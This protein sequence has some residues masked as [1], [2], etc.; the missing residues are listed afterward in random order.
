MLRSFT[1]IIKNPWKD[2][3]QEV[4]RKPTESGSLLHK[5]NMAT[6]RR[7]TGGGGGNS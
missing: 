1:H 6:M 5:I 3:D 7:Q 4:G 2:S